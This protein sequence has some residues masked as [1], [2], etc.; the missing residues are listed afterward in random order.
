MYLMLRAV[1][2]TLFGV[3]GEGGFPFPL[4]LA[5]S[6]TRDTIHP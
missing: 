1:S 3:A 5:R 4:S 6:G 2:H